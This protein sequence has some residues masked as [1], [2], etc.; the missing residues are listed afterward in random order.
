MDIRGL[1]NM[2]NTCYLNSVIQCLYHTN[3]FSNFCKQ[4]DS[5]DT[6]F[7]SYKNLINA[8]CK[9]N[10]DSMIMPKTFK[11]TLGEYNKN[12]S[13]FNPEDAH[14]FL[15]FFIDYMN[16]KFKNINNIFYGDLSSVIGCINKHQSITKDKFSN[17]SLP[18]TANSLEDCMRNYFNVENIE[19]YHCEKCK[20]KIHAKK[21]YNI[22]KFPNILIIHFKRLLLMQ[23]IDAMITFPTQLT[24][25]SNVYELYALINHFGNFFGGH[26]TSMIKYNDSWHHIN[27]EK[28]D[29]IPIQNILTNNAYILFYKKTN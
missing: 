28:I 9:S 22:D 19:D 24:L 6:L 14:E 10:D 20:N 18:I 23:K 26:Y 4:K 7:N 27:D 5:E 11:T 17:L 25:N 8:I 15:T 1:V 2:G 3:I 12:Y 16:D 13:K 29:V 21:V